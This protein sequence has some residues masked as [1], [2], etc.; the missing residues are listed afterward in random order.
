MTRH[1]LV[2]LVTKIFLSTIF[3]QNMGYWNEEIL[4]ERT[5]VSE[6]TNINKKKAL[7]DAATLYMPTNL[8]DS[9]SF[10]VSFSISAYLN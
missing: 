9:Q 7:S 6:R 5:G 8:R 10:Y 1:H 2:N 3:V 4:F